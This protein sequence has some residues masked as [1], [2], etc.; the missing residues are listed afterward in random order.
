MIFLSLTSPFDY[1]VATPYLTNGRYD[2]V[3]IGDIFPESCGDPK[4]QWEYD[5]HGL[6]TTMGTIS[7]IHSEVKACA[8]VKREYMW[9]CHPSHNGI[10]TGGIR[11]SIDSFDHGICG[12]P[13]KQFDVKPEYWTTRLGSSGFATVQPTK[14]PGAMGLWPT[15]LTNFI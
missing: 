11:V 14:N 15:I 10:F 6:H 3:P 12:E 5:G 2:S 4:N 7:I 13:K 9:H 1:N 8:M